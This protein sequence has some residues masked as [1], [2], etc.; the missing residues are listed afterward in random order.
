[1]AKLRR[2][3]AFSALILL[4]EALIGGP[5]RGEM[6]KSSGNFKTW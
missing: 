3:A 1:M 6:L 2:Y 4:A 5:G